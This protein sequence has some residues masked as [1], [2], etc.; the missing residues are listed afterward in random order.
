[1][2]LGANYL[3]R[4]RDR[5]MSW[6]EVGGVDLTR[7]IDRD[8]L[9]IMG[10]PG[11]E[12]Q[13][14][15]N[16]GIS[17][18]GNITAFAE[19]PLTP[20]LLYVGTDDGN[21]QVSRD[22]GA[23]WTNVA[24][25]IPDL[26]ERTYVSRLEPSHHAE[27]RV[28]ASFDGHRNADYA[29]YVY[30]SEDHGDSWRRITE[31]LPDGWSVNVVTEHHRAP[32][33]LFVGN[34]IG[35]FLSVDRGERW[36]QLKNNLPVVPVDDILVHPRDNDLLVGTHGR[37]FWILAD[38]SP[39]EHLSAQTLAEAGRIFPQARETI[40]WAQRGDWPFAG[41][42]YS[43]PN[44]PRGTLIRYY[45]RDAWEAPMAEEEGEEGGDSDDGDKAG[46]GDGGD[47]ADGEPAEESTFALTITD[48]DGGHVR[49]LDAP[50]D[51]GVNEVVWDW[52]MDA[53]YEPEGPQQP[54]GFG[55]PGTPQGPI[56]LPGV[57]TVSM[58][59]G[60]QTH[61]STVE[62][63]ADPRRPMTRADRTA[64]QDALMSLHALAAP[65]YEAGRAVDRLEE[66]LDAAEE[67]IEAAAEAPEGLAEELA[68]IREAL[69]E[70]DDDV[71]EARRNAGVATA[72]Q[73]SSTLPTED[74]MWQVDRAWEVMAELLDPLNELVTSRV[75]ALNAQ[76]YA[77]GVRPKPG[78]A[79]ALPGR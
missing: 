55:Q 6:E 38:V 75:L 1:M 77:E 36:V 60:G 51:A 61:S 20:G 69:D 7:Q 17:T 57:Y 34:E 46:T 14:S 68:A 44:P 29:A 45:L 13:M 28:Y 42:T 40:M 70:I 52:R 66:Q 18:Y 26:P 65:I 47:M 58:E 15:V 49:T 22:D 23:T 30:V 21:V 31:G 71:G 53:P 72:I 63:R 8:E 43:A 67:L 9:E 32:N 35:V 41:A 73:G 11:S 50:G 25:R 39:L 76:L 16:D 24:E 78:E 5:G 56:A 79:V 2:Y 33:L 19:S 59:A 3:L 4:S 27:G 48:S 64:R 10:V 62:I 54:V 12:P 37:S 74:Q